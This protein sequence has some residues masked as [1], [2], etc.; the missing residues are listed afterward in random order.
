[1]SSKV[2]FYCL[3]VWLASVILGPALFW[4]CMPY[5][6]RDASYTFTD[7]LGF[8][9]F[10]ILYGLGFS[11]VS[12]LLFWVATMYVSRSD[13]ASGRRRLAI[14]VSGI[15]LTVAPFLILF[16]TVGFFSLGARVLFCASYLI[17]ILAGIFFYRFPC[18]AERGAKVDRP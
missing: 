12:F 7:F 1:M 5:I 16:G 14:A 11:L 4:N 6:D 15:V 8:W 17:P 18:Q 13:W 2:F 3:K 10:G 9:F